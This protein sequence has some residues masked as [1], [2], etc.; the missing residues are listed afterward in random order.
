MALNAT[1]RPNET[2][3]AEPASVELP[4]NLLADCDDN[5]GFADFW[6]DFAVDKAQRAR[7]S[8]EPKE[9]GDV[10]RLLPALLD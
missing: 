7:E 2:G 6:G 1:A 9:R 4:T 5:G 8:F 3:A 10:D